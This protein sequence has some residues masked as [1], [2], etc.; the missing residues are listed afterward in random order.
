MY[1]FGCVS[2]CLCSIYVHPEGQRVL[3]IFIENQ[4]FSPMQDLAPSPSPLSLRK[5]SLFPVFLSYIYVTGWAYWRERGEGW[6]RSQIIRRQ[7]W[8]KATQCWEWR[9]RCLTRKS[10]KKIRHGEFIYCFTVSLASRAVPCST[11]LTRP[12]KIGETA[13]SDADNPPPPPTRT[14]PPQHII[15]IG[16]TKE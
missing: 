9:W 13:V 16:P 15:K 14:P 12:L 7:A 6:G 5:L 10:I 11:P 1:S 3:K 2:P 8:P 4:A